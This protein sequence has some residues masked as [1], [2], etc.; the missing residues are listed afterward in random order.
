VKEALASLVSTEQM[1]AETLVELEKQARTIDNIEN[2]IEDI[3][4]KLDKTERL[5]RGIESLPAYI[6]NSLSKKKDTTPVKISQDR[7]IQVAKR[8]A[9]P[10]EI[11]ILC[12]NVDCSFQLALLSFSED[13]FQCLDIETQKLL[14]P[15]FSFLFK[16]ISEVALRTRPEHMDFRFH[17]PRSHKDRFRLMSSY[18]QII[19]NEL[20]YRTK[21]KI[22][23]VFESGS[24]PFDYGTERISTVPPIPRKQVEKGF[25]F[26]GNNPDFKL[27]SLVSDQETKEQLEEVD[28]HLT[29]ISSIL[30]RVYDMSLATGAEIDRQNEQ[31]ERV[32]KKVDAQDGRI[33]MVNRRIN[34]QIN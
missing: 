4:A 23:V 16:D 17:P 24:T 11:E 20:F 6:G 33:D 34:N 18:N 7:S 2:T 3:S 29:Q 25:V 32:N 28:S 8:T 19:V 1:G 27:S 15:N 9:P 13:G 31:L 5:M 12:K 30:G 22:K 14:H 21:G 26:R 10:M